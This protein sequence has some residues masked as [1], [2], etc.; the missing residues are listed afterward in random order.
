M[1][2]MWYFNAG[3]NVSGGQ[4]Q[5]SELRKNAFSSSTQLGL[6]YLE[7]WGLNFR[8]AFLRFNFHDSNNNIQ[9]NEVGFRLYK[10]IFSDW[11]KGTFTLLLGN[12]WVI[13]PDVD[14]TRVLYPEI[15]YLN[16]TKS[17]SLGV[18]YANSIYSGITNPSF[19]VNQFTGT[20]GFSVFTKR[21]WFN[22]KNYLIQHD[23]LS[24]YTGQPSFVWYLPR[25]S[26]F[27]PSRLIVGGAIGK[28]VY[29]VEQETMLVYNTPDVQKGSIFSSVQWRLTDYFFF[30][31]TMGAEYFNAQTNQKRY[32]YSFANS[33]VSAFW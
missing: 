23:G 1:A 25:S 21:F 11:P 4:Y 12:Y 32:Q 7:R 14:T 13:G 20:L 10:N 8:T 19:T 33:S 6:H 28:R 15:N 30:S 9:Q 22:L 17:V 31:L 16:P 26:R 18:G 5:Q 2:E 27:I 3:V 29:A 24:Y